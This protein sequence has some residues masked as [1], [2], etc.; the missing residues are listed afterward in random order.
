VCISNIFLQSTKRAYLN[1]N[2]VINKLVEHAYLNIN[3]VINK[4]MVKRLL[5]RDVT[6]VPVLQVTIQQHR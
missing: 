3:P 5:I 4:L 6:F 2:C 1:I